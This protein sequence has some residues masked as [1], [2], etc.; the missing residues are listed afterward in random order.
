MGSKKD[1]VNLLIKIVRTIFE[2]YGKD[3]TILGGNSGRE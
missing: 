1:D 2:A 3:G